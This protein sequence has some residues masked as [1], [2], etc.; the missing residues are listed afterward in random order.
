[1]TRNPRL[2]K[3]VLEL[4]STLFRRT[5]QREVFNSHL[6][7]GKVGGPSTTSRCRGW[8]SASVRSTERR[9][10]R[11]S[12]WTT[13]SSTWPVST[14]SFRS[15]VTWGTAWKGRELHPL[16]PPRMERRF[17][18]NRAP[19][20]CEPT[21]VPRTFPKSFRELDERHVGDLLRDAL[22]DLSMEVCVHGRFPGNNI[23]QTLQPCFDYHHST[24]VPPYQRRR[25]CLFWRVV[26]GSTQLSLVGTR[27]LP[28][29]KVSG[30]SSTVQLLGSMTWL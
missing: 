15:R 30:S 21:L 18:S 10:R 1:M 27:R 26:K 24:T 7:V 17:L 3:R 16:R 11:S 13:S 2:R 5:L 8:Y 12:C 14:W 19:Q 29:N 22:L 23:F 25:C 28:T 4:T 9:S 20:A 6:S